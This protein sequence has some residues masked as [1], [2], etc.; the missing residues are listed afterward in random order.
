MN[1][2]RVKNPADGSIIDVP[3]GVGAKG[4]SAYEY[5]QEGGYTGTEAEFAEDSNPDNIKAELSQIEAPEI[6]S[7]VA[8]MTDTSKH[9][10]FDRSI[11]Y[12]GKVVTGGEVTSP[13]MFVPS[14]AE[15]NKRWSISSS[16]S[17]KQAGYFITDFIEV[18]NFA[19]T[20]PYNA[21][22]NWELPLTGNKD[23]KMIFFNSDKTQIGAS[24]LTEKTNNVT[25]LNGKTVI[26][27]KSIST[28]GGGYEPT[29]SEVAYVKL[30]LCI[31]SSLSSLTS[32]DIA[33][34]EITFD[35]NNIEIEGTVTYEWIDS[36]ISYAPTFKT[37][38]IGVLGENN[39]IY[40]SDNLPSGTYTLKTDSANYDT[41]GTY[42]VE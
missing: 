32:A 1:I 28:V 21:R 41:I 12:Y 10:V 36:G 19:N 33:N 29:A 9:Y 23:N 2:L 24:F 8:D 26:N 15:L 14:T 5:A 35:A 11:Y 18:K 30:E 17:S 22:L 20:T 16:A 27:M 40:L 34:C 42:I 37:D 25:V 38:L 13:N 6:V 31:E 3:F 39:V 7:S 4:K